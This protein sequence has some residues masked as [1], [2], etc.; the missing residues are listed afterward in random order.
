M[1]T[2]V[3]NIKIWH[4]NRDYI[5]LSISLLVIIIFLELTLFNYKFYTNMFNEPFTVTPTYNGMIENYGNEE[6]FFG[7]GD[8][9]IELKNINRHIKNIYFDAEVLDVSSKS[10]NDKITINLSATDA[11]NELYFS[12]PERVIV[13]GNSQSKYIMLNLNGDTEKLKIDI[14][15]CDGKTVEL[16]PIVLN[17]KVPFQFNIVRIFVL[18]ALISMAYIIKPRNG[19]YDYKFDFNSNRQRRIITTIAVLNIAVILALG[20]AHPNKTINAASNHHQYHWLAEAIMDGHFY[21]NDEPSE[22][23]K[24]LDN[25]YDRRARD[26]AMKKSGDRYKWDVAYY[27]GKYYV[28]FGVVPELLFFLPTRLMGIMIVNKAPVIIMTML[29]V[30][31]AFLLVR[32]LTRR[33]FSDTS[34]LLYTMMS[35]LFANCTGVFLSIRIPDLYMIPISHAFA[36]SLM[37]IYCWVMALPEKGGTKLRGGYLLLGS[38]CIALIAGCR[39]QCEV[40]AFFAIPLFWKAV[41]KDRELFSSKTIAKTAGFVLPF[42]IVAAFLMYYNY[43]RFGNPFDF[44]ANYNL[45][46]MDMVSEKFNPLKIPLALYT[47]FIQPPYLNAVFPFIGKVNIAKGFM[48]NYVTEAQFGGIFMTNFILLSLLFVYKVKSNLESRKLYIPVI[49]MILFCVLISIVDSNTGGIILRYMIDFKWLIFIAGI[50]VIYAM[51]E[52]YANC[53]FSNF[54]YKFVSVGFVFSLAYTF[55]LAFNID[56]GSY[57]NYL[58]RFFYFVE[59]MIEFWV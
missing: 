23:L 15:G 31:F 12:L 2:L 1:K 43:A 50:L 20:F 8:K 7:D 46:T 10:E 13:K 41:F 29:A 17:S 4:K 53:P 33:W 59:H 5:K 45:T 21:L 19:F 22:T 27:E 47:Y 38:I 11:G 44:G 40:I 25:P 30:I 24:N 55:C 36:F 37:G 14:N 39:P 28:Y 32:E 52:K 57:K 56:A 18:F 26:A 48:G 16:K 49:M 9:S 6:F 3:S 54:F 42:V 35:I 58:P 51:A 34:F